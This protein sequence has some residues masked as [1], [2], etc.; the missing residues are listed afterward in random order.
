M[1]NQFWNELLNTIEVRPNRNLFPSSEEQ[2]VAF[3]SKFG[4]KLPDDYRGFCKIFGSG[5]FGDIHI[6]GSR[7]DDLI[8]DWIK[9]IV[10]S[11]YEHDLIDAN[12]LSELL[13]MLNSSLLFGSGNNQSFFLDSSHNV[14]ALDFDDL[15]YGYNFGF[16]FT[17]FI[18]NYCLN[19]E[20]QESLPD[21]W[22]NRSEISDIFYAYQM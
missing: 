14:Y 22:R 21:R 17:L 5:S 10:T 20:F 6:V 18:L 8:P 3:E 12:E 2:I 19:Q 11:K 16:G 4:L 13:A 7:L 1:S 9:D 15:I